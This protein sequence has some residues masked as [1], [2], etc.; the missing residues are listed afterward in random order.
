MRKMKDITKLVL[1]LAALSMMALTGCRSM[2]IGSIPMETLKN[3]YQV[4]DSDFITVNGV[5]FHYKDEGQGPV[6]LLFHGICSSL[7][8][9]DGWVDQLKGKYRIIRMD[10]PGWGLTGPV[11]YSMD[12]DKM[13]VL[14]EDVVK[15]LE[16]DSFYIAGNS[17]GGYFAWNYALRHPEQV[18][19]MVLLDPVCYPQTPPWFIRIAKYPYLTYMSRFMMP[20]WMVDMNVKAVYGDPAKID[21]RIYDLYFDLSM[22]KGNK[23]SYMDAFRFMAEESVKDTLSKGVPDIKTPVLLMYGSKDKWVPPSQEYLWKKDLPGTECIIYEGAGHVPMEEM[24]AMTARDADKFFSRTDNE[25]LW[26]GEA[27]PADEENK[28][29]DVEGMA[30]VRDN[31]S[32][33][34]TRVDENVS[35]KETATA[36]RELEDKTGGPVLVSRGLENQADKLEFVT[37]QSI[38]DLMGTQAKTMEPVR[39]SNGFTSHDDALGDGDLEHF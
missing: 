22:R 2:G 10:L 26:T 11:E 27:L 29:L 15:K 7:Y 31:A 8:T 37:G 17:L 38:G 28:R 9:W 6:L 12:L 3:K 19:K 35:F 33:V 20:K 24:P 39:T 23:G 1:A 25:G 30:M 21:D 5:S 14:M 18:K 4:A 13:L 36:S 34:L 32:P 16:L